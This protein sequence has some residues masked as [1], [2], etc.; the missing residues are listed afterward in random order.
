MS[1]MSLDRGII[2]AGA[3]VAGALAETLGVGAGIAAM[4][5]ILLALSGVAM[6][7]LI[8][9]LNDIKPHAA[10][11]RRVVHGAG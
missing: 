11:R 6:V 2:P 8:P 1:L 10:P 5:I 4:A 7:L 9:R 3:L